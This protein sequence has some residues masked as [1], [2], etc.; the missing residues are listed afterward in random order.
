M[1]LGMSQCGKY[2][3][4]IVQ[5]LMFAMEHLKTKVMTISFKTE[6]SRI[7]SELRNFH[8]Q[9]TGSNYNSNL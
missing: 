8:V 7:R 5:K 6:A 2:N 4:R 9:I 3:H 1:L